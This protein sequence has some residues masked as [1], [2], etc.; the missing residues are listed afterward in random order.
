MCNVKHLTPYVS[1]DN[2]VLEIEHV[3]KQVWLAAVMA[4]SLYTL[5]EISTIN[6]IKYDVNIDKSEQFIMKTT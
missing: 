3:E 4:Y 1:R 6:D 2:Y 5:R